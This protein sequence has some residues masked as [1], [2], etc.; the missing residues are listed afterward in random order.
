VYCAEPGAGVM[1]LS[2]GSAQYTF[3]FYGG[4]DAYPFGRFRLATTLP[5]GEIVRPGP[6]LAGRPPMDW[7]SKWPPRLIREGTVSYLVFHTTEGDDPPENPI[8][9]SAS[10]RD[11]QALVAAHGGELVHREYHNQEARVWVYR[12]T[13]LLPAPRLSATWLHRGPDGAGSLRVSGRGFRIESKVTVFFHGRYL[14]VYGTDDRGRF[15]A[16]VALEQNVKPRY[17]LL[18]RDVAGNEASVPSL[19]IKAE[20]R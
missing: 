4:L 3:S 6:T 1:V 17:L 20:H 9:T 14:G 19:E 12:V 15:S 18:A 16:R 7:I 10:H 11:F 5:G 8:V 2:N 13:K